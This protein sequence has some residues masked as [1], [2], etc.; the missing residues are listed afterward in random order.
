MSE[1]F[2]EEVCCGIYATET[3]PL[4]LP[5][6]TIISRRADNCSPDGSDSNKGGGLLAAKVETGT[7][8]LWQRLAW[9]P[10]LSAATPATQPPH[11]RLLTA[12]KTPDFF[13]NYVL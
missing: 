12:S 2:T 3:A 7:L 9:W 4:T 5:T 10:D 6:G 8:P 11:R 13:E 1:C